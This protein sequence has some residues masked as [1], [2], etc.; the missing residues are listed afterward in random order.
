[1]TYPG[2]DLRTRLVPP[3]NHGPAPNA[4]QPGFNLEELGL[5]NQDSR[6]W[7]FSAAAVKPELFAPGLANS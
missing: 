6:D 3:W 7:L 1:M 4:D 5:L 2:D